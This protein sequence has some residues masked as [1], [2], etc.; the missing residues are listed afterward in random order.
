MA[1]FSTVIAILFLFEG[2]KRIGA[3]QAAIIK[4]IEPMVTVVMSAL[5]LGDR[6]SLPQLIGGALIIIGIVVL[7][8]PVKEKEK[9]SE[10][11]SIG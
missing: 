5:V 7:Q 1:I 10:D 11:N 2:I 8:R 6:M 9:V 3:S 4:T